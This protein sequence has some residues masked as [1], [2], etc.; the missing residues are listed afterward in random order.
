M[1]TAVCTWVKKSEPLCLKEDSGTGKS[2]LLS[3]LG[4]EAALHGFR[5]RYMLTTKHLNELA[6]ALAQEHHRPSLGRRTA[7]GHVHSRTTAVPQEGRR[8]GYLQAPRGRG[9]L[10]PASRA[11]H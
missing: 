4:T 10:R 5:V 3:T 11:R 1:A 6:E 7:K 2:H 8:P 9:Y